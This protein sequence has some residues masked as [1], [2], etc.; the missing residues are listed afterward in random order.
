[1]SPSPVYIGV[2][3][4]KR[5]LET[6]GPSLLHEYLNVPQGHAKIIKSLPQHDAHVVME[7][8]GD[9]QRGFV[10]ALHRAGIKVSV[11]NARHVR[12]F[13]K[14]MGQNAKTDKIDAAMIARYA[15]AKS[16]RPD[17]VPSEAQLRLTEMVCRRGQLVEARVME[18][19]RLEHYYV[20]A[21][22]KQA[23]ATI[24]FLNQKIAE[25]EKLIKS[26]IASD[27]TLKMNFDRLCQADG[28]GFIVATA[29][30]AYMPE[31][32]KVGRKEAAALLGV[33]PFIC[34]S[35]L[36]GRCRQ[37]FGGR[38]AA[39]SVV[40][41]AA[42]TAVR[43][44]TILKAFYKNLRAKKPFKVAIVAVMRKLIMLL[45]HMLKNPDFSLA[46]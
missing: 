22:R 43:K 4:S 23:Q 35:A 10:H 18:T 7:A 30:L 24:E 13:A 25:L 6:Q 5:T 34:E 28:I 27:E 20:P 17:P 45:N 3:V 40:Y 32:G 46:S 29:L 38:A 37:I 36:R 39:R 16:P 44:N 33:A 12:D 26:E 11:V 19:N 2:D 14:S 42:L 8:T 41:M 31:L 9:Y 15:S 1:M 21:V